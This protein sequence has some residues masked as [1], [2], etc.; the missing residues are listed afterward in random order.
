MPKHLDLCCVLS[1]CS[2]TGGSAAAF[3]LGVLNQLPPACMSAAELRC[4]LGM[5][6]MSDSYSKGFPP[7]FWSFTVKVKRW[8]SLTRANTPSIVANLQF[9]LQQFL[10]SSLTLDMHDIMVTGDQHSTSKG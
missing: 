6:V 7:C 1:P 9:M 4:T 3:I 2:R 10:L 5:R 8:Y